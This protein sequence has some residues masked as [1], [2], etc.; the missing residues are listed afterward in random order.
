MGRIF[1]IYLLWLYFRYVSAVEV[2]LVI[3]L[4]SPFG[5]AVCA[6]CGTA[7]VFVYVCLGALATTLLKISF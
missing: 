3:I 5:I 1:L 7:Q 2:E 4:D 6:L